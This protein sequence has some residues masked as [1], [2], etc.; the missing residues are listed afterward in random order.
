ME[1]YYSTAA[2]IRLAQQM[3]PPKLLFHV[4]KRNRDPCTCKK[5]RKKINAL[6]ILLL[7]NISVACS[8]YALVFV[9]CHF[10]ISGL[11]H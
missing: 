10:V 11:F 6:N 2:F 5:P 1:N 4:S 8:G 9:H 7:Y 3:F